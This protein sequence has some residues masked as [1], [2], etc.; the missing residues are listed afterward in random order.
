M[1]RTGKNEING[2]LN[3]MKGLKE[4][5]MLKLKA[6]ESTATKKVN[7]FFSIYELFKCCYTF[8]TLP[9][10]LQQFDFSCFAFHKCFTMCITKKLLVHSQWLWRKFR[11]NLNALLTFIEKGSIWYDFI[12]K[13]TFHSFNR[14]QF[15]TKEKNFRRL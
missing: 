5:K 14:S 1:R 12:Y 7:L 15:S 11:I 13:I 9:S 10:L 3:G 4:L 2:K 8:F 6:F